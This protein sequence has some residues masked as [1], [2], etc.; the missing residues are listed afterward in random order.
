MTSRRAAWHDGFEI[1]LRHAVG[2]LGEVESIVRPRRVVDEGLAVEQVSDP[3]VKRDDDKAD[4]GDRGHAEPHGLER[5]GLERGRGLDAEELL[6]VAIDQADE[7]AAIPVL[8]DAFEVE[9]HQVVPQARR[10]AAGP[11][12]MLPLQ[13]LRR[14]D[15]DHVRAAPTDLTRPRFI[16]RIEDLDHQDEL[17][18]FAPESDHLVLHDD[19]LSRK[20]DRENLAEIVHGP[21]QHAEVSLRLRPGV[22]QVVTFPAQGFG[23]PLP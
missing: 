5:G 18:C 10:P 7:R 11:A 20:G 21:L 23:Q 4:R 12:A 3:L 2:Q 15:L 6:R 14:A 17:A 22:S 19:R 1:P 9:E 16:P 8:V 13:E